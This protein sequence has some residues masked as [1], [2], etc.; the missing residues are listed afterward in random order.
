M[1]EQDHRLI[2]RLLNAGM[3][4]KKLL[5]L[6]NVTLVDHETA[7]KMGLAIAST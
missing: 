7:M 4:H 2:K 5:I 3:W 1:I 6:K